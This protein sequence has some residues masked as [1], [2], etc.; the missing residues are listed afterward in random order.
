MWYFSLTDK[1]LHTYIAWCLSVIV[2]LVFVDFTLKKKK[3]SMKYE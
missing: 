1:H 2:I 3:M